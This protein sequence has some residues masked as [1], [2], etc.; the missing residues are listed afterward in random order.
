[1]SDAQAD[2]KVSHFPAVTNGSVTETRLNDMVTRILAAWYHLGQDAGYPEIGV[3]PYDQQHPIIDVRYDHASLIRE[4]GAAGTVLVKNK[5]N[6][7]PLDKP[8]FLNIYGYDAKAPDSPWTT[9]SRFGGGY[10]VNFGWETFNGTLIT[11]GGSGGSS[12]SSSLF[13]IRM[14]HWIAR[15]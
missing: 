11:G 3:Y 15:V 7:L 10:D 6:A 12:V 8:R 1:M 5:D 4:I 13:Q 2:A 14:I 9:P